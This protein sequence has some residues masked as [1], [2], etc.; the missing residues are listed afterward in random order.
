MKYFV[1]FLS[2]FSINLGPSYHQC[3]N[4]SASNGAI[5]KG[6]NDA[7]KESFFNCLDLD[8]R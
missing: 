6:S 2:I 5:N 7:D 4:S 3:P 8:K 1:D